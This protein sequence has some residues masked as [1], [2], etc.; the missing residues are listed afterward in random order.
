VRRFVV[1]SLTFILLSIAVGACGESTPTPTTKGG[2]SGGPI[3]YC[4]HEDLQVPVL[5]SP[6]D[7]E[8]I[9]IPGLTFHW[10]Y[11]TTDCI[12]EEFE[13]Q[14]AQ[15][16]GFL[17]Y[18]GATV[19][20]GVDEWS[21]EVELLPAT[22][23]YWRIRGM[24]ADDAGPW[25]PTW[26]FFTGP[27]CESASLVAPMAAFP[28]GDMFELDAPTFEWSYPEETCVPPGYHLQISPTE[29]L[30][31]LLLDLNQPTPGTL[32]VPT[33]DY[34]DCTVYYW[35][36]AASDGGADGPF[37]EVQYFSINVGGDCSEAC[38]EDQLVEPVPISP[39]RYANLGLAPTVEMVPGL[40]QWRYPIPCLPGGF[41]IH[42][43][44]TADFSTPILGGGA[45]P[46][47]DSEVR[48]SPPALL[49]PATQYYWE[50]FA[51]IGT[52][53]GPASPLRS[54]FTG[55]ECEV[56]ADSLP[57]TLLTPG[58]GDVVDSLTPW[59]HWTAGAGSCIPDGYEIFL[60]TDLD[61][62]AEDYYSYL[63]TIPATTFFPDPLDDCTTYYWQIAPLLDGAELPR[64][65]V[66]SFTMQTGPQCGQGQLWGRAIRETACRFGPG[67]AWHILGYFLA[68]EQSPIAGTDM[69]RRW[70]AVD[71]PDNPGERC[72]VPSDNIEPL[73]DVGKLRILN[74]PASP[75]EEPRSPVCS[76]SLN[77]REA[78][79]A[80]GGTWGPPPTG[81]KDVCT[82]H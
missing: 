52:T 34:E 68:G 50:V 2:G 48:W 13:I 75:T 14:V 55:P 82:C 17:G 9:D 18:S 19:D 56:A 5:Y 28:L 57:P 25:S 20:V 45:S 22:V 62:T 81:G 29:D 47:T 15:N 1:L 58:D 54:F 61:S 36:V 24:V 32:A 42:L 77:T 74:P 6:T 11:N 49:E 40:L 44:T 27:A 30:S 35:R 72:W 23:Y 41:G 80:A 78:C 10:V 12:P 53:F 33:V 46:V 4:S 65:D 51:G 3:P 73:G 76:T 21:P 39:A 8:N 71:N 63:P 38:T 37:S 64:S 69:A 26:S 70:Y 31:T 7:G 67:T 59:L 43:S 16:H 60:G 79:E 66:W